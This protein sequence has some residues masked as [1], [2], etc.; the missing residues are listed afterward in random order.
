MSPIAKF[1][2]LDSGEPNERSGGFISCIEIIVL[3]SNA[4]EVV[5]LF[6]IEWLVYDDYI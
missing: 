2:P 3:V 4:E 5:G 1:T 6:S